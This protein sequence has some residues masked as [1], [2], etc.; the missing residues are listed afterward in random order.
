MTAPVL[1]VE[2]GRDGRSEELFL[3]VVRGQSIVFP[4][5]IMPAVHCRL[6]KS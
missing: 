2:D 5:S 3:H 6:P 4:L 1:N